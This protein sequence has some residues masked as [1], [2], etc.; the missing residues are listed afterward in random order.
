[1]PTDPID[2]ITQRLVELGMVTETSA[3]M[4]STL[5][6]AFCSL[7]GSKYAATV[8]GGQAASWLIDQCRALTTVHREITAEH[9]QAIMDAL[10]KCKSANEKRNT[11]IH[12]VK[13]ASSVPDGSLQTIRSR[14]STH[15]PVVQ[16]WTLTEIHAAVCELAKAN[17]SLF[18]AMIAAV[19]E[20][21]MVL[22]HALAWEEKRAH[23][24]GQ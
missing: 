19:S 23:E 21:M 18:A 12:S 10:D 3:T 6:S 11:L 14:R 15:V 24:E 4:E 8:A 5:R 13:T 20:Q 2:V 9:K 22:D 1:M 16:P 17:S 7:V